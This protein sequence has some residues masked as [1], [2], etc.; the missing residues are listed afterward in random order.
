MLK[1]LIVDDHPLF[2]EALAQIAAELADVVHCA[3][4]ETLERALHLIGN[5]EC[6]DL[7]V[8]DLGLP[9]ASGLSGVLSIRD[10]ASTTPVVIV[11]AS[12]NGEIIGQAMRLGVSGY[13]PKSAPREVIL[14]ALVKIL[15]GGTY[16]PSLAAP[17][18]VEGGAQPTAQAM[19]SLTPRQLTVLRLL[20]E[21]KPNKQIAYELSISQ[22]TVKIHIS[23]ILRKLKVNSRSQAIL[24]ANRLREPASRLTA[25]RLRS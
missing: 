22:E 1:V 2:R 23:A 14:A 5:G 12:E 19:E 6:F 18:G 24:F 4:A 8:L 20:G 11:S 3:Q 17:E 25:D 10:Q 21:G 13:V 7:V 16:F 9:G 15:N